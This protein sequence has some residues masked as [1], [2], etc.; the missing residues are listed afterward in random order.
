MNETTNQIT[1]QKPDNNKTQP[2]ERIKPEKQRE[3]KKI[4]A[5]R[6]EEGIYVRIEVLG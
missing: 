3:V 1:N 6:N 5:T 2:H 4:G